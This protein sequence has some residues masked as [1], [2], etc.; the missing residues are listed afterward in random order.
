MATKDVRCTFSLPGAEYD[1]VQDLRRKLGDSLGRKVKKSELL[2]IA[3]R[4]LLSQTQVKIKT[5][6]SKVATDA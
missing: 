2:R 5:E 1:A 4:I 3:T 6:L